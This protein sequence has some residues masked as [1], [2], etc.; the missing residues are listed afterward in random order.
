YFYPSAS[1]SW[2]VSET[3]KMP[4]AISFAKV[5]INASQ[6]GSDTWAY[7]LERS[8]VNLDRLGNIFEA[9][10]ENTLKNPNLKPTRTNQYEAG[11]DLRFFRNRLSIDFAAYSGTSF[12]QITPVNIAPSTGY[13]YRYVN[14]GEVSNKGL[15]LALGGTPVMREEWTWELG[16]TWSKNINE[17][18]SLA[19]GVDALPI[20]YGYSG[21]RTEARPGMPYGNII[22]YGLKRDA[23]GRIVHVNGLPV[24]TDSEMVLGNITPDWA[25]SI[26]TRL[27]YKNISLSALVNARYGGEVFSLTTQWLRQFGLDEATDIPLRQGAVIGDGVMEQIVDGEVVYV[28]NNV[29]VPFSEYS[30]WFNA[31]GLQ[32]TAIFDASYVKLK[33]LRLSYDIPSKHL[34]KFPGNRVTVAVMGR[35]LALLY[36]RIP[37]VDPE[38]SITADNSKQGFEI[39]NMPSARTVAF[40]L[41]V[42]F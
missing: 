28:T 11:F 35:N 40:N 22:G 4:E 14:I 38:T 30:Y 31:Y 23:E 7:Q 6:V 24:K 10:V 5:R 36:S 29:S 18:I 2:V 15:E 1:L 41:T 34:R 42:T 37:H 26:S 33:E 32:E 16:L 25:G 20:G 13:T 12:D 19:E 9:S 17:V 27:K 3:F 39:F 8:F 21:I